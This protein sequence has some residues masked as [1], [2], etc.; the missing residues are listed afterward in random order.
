MGRDD[1][2][3]HGSSRFTSRQASGL[4]NIV[5][6]VDKRLLTEHARSV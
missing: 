4:P 2:I 1:L 6:W 3:S 5:G